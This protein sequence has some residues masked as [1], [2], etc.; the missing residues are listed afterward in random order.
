LKTLNEIVSDFKTSMAEAFASGV[1]GPIEK[2]LSGERPTGQDIFKGFQSGIASSIANAV[3]QA[4]KTTL[5]GGMGE[6]GFSNF[7]QNFKNFQKEICH[8]LIPNIVQISI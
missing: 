3:G 8:N 4:F 5:F 2:I 6:G 7:F 1:S